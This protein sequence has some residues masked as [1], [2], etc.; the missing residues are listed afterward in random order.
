MFLAACSRDGFD[1]VRG[2]GTSATESRTVPAFTGIE[3][4]N[5]ASVQV[6][7]GPATTVAVTSDDNLVP[8]VKTRVEGDTLEIYAHQSLQPTDGIKVRITTPS[9]QAVS[10]L[11]SGRIRACGIKADIFSVNVSGAGDI[12]AEGTVNRCSVTVEGAGHIKASDLVAHDCTVKIE[13]A[14]AVSVHADRSMDASIEGTGS[15][16]YRGHPGQVKKSVEGVGSIEAD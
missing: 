13:G 11:G 2:S 9:L 12:T 3:I 6:D 5:S 10:I 7:V 4:K 14:G 15:I 1:V 16:R 8:L